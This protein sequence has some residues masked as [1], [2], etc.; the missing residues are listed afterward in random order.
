MLEALKEKVLKANMALPKYN[1]V[2]FTWGNVS[3]IERE[4]NLVV[5]KPSGVEYDVMTAE[6]MVVV[7]L[8]TGKVVEGSKKPSSDTPT[9][10]ELYR[11]FPTIGGIVHTHSRHATIWS[12]AGEDLIAAGTTHA[13]YF[14]GA[15][16]CTRKMTPAE[17]QGE[18]ELETGK[19]IVETFRKR[20]IEPK[21]VPAVLVHSH[22][23]FAWGTDADNAVHNAVVLEEIGYMNL[24]SRQLRPNLQP[25]QQELLDKHYL[26][27]HG[28][29]AY[30]GQ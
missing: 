28:K 18:Y 23:P 21:D 12:Q 6:D 10:L 5:I 15:I 4:K 25:M 27:K 24:F 7:D 30:Y 3:A 22:G 9:H 1:L 14:Y 17:I 20:G 26:R 2:T 8:F 19:V 13:D 11:E 29:N 16:P